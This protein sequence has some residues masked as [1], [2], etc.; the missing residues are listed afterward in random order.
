MLSDA[1]NRPDKLVR[2]SKKW[3]NKFRFQCALL[4]EGKMEIGEIP[5]FGKFFGLL[6]IL[7]FA[8]QSGI[9]FVLMSVHGQRDGVPG[10]YKL[11][12]LR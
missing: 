9:V 6:S 12:A 11:A 1:K 3:T 10:I 5:F 8:D 7:S 2:E 4:Q